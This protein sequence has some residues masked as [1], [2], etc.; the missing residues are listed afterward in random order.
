MPAE[1]PLEFSKTLLVSPNSLELAMALLWESLDKFHELRGG[2]GGGGEGY[3]LKLGLVTCFLQ[4]SVD[5]VPQEITR[6][7][8]IFLEK[9]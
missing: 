4:C 8:Y 2:G 3:W 5:K 6:Q 9:S 7:M 1:P